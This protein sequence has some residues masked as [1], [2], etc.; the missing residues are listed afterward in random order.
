MV[1]VT[2]VLYEKYKGSEW[3]LNGDPTNETEFKNGFTLHKANG[4]PEPK[5]DKIQEYLISMQTAYDALAYSRDR[6]KPDG[7]APIEE[8]LD[9]QYWDS[10]NGT[11]KWKDHIAK[12]KSDHP[13]E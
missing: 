13:K 6:V 2:D 3:V 10:V 5:W 8:Q 11:T 9:M 1:D 7:Y 12:V 4:V